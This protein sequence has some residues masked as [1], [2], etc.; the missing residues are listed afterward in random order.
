MSIKKISTVLTVVALV[1]LAGCQPIPQYGA[2]P[3]PKEK[4]HV[5]VRHA[6]CTGSGVLW[7][8]DAT[9]YI[10]MSANPTYNTKEVTKTRTKALKAKCKKKYDKVTYSYKE[11]D[12]G[13]LTL[14]GTRRE[15]ASQIVKLR[16]KWYYNNKNKDSRKDYK[17]YSQPSVLVNGLEVGKSKTYRW[18]VA[19]GKKPDFIMNVRF[20]RVL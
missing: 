8:K 7:V 1:A 9:A 3:E 20:K 17:Q 6:W 2:V 19:G 12:A 14:E 11:G 13:I 4:W 16:L 18:T 15:I 10:S 5:Y